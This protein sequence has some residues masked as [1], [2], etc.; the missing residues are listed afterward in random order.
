MADKVDNSPF[1]GLA[2]MTI[3]L[4]DLFLMCIQLFML[5]N[6]CNSMR[7]HDD[8]NMLHVSCSAPKFDSQDI[9]TDHDTTVSNV[10][11]TISGMCECLAFSS[12]SPALDWHIS[13]ATFRL[14]RALDKITPYRQIP[15]HMSIHTTLAT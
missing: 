11:A 5:C 1:I 14:A 8:M 3:C 13:E 4:Y 6:S 7:G 9:Q 10:S 15:N 12:A 2:S